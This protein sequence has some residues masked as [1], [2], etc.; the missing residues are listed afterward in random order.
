MIATIAFITSRHQPRFDWFLESLFRQISP[1]DIIQVIIVDFYAQSCDEW[2]KYDADKRDEKLCGL[3]T[4]LQLPSN[5]TVERHP[6]MPS[7]WQ[8][9]DRLTKENWWA[10]AAARNTALCYAKHSWFLHLDDRCVLQPGFLDAARENMLESKFTFGTYQKRTGITVEN[11]LIKNGGI[12]TANDSRA[13]YV[14]QHRSN[15]APTPCPGEWYF[16]C[17]G[18]GPLEWYL[19]VNGWDT[20]CDGQSME[21]TI[22]GLMIANNGYPTFFDNRMAIVEDRTPEDS[23]PV[24]IRRDK[25]VSPNDRSHA[26]LDMLKGLK[27]AKHNVDLREIRNSILNG[28]SFPPAMEPILDWYDG[29]LLSD[30]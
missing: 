6:P 16:G 7:V 21:D 4:Y 1:S 20:T 8:G 19:S 3:L 14:R 22:L 13:D 28:K 26:L 17:C 12:I 24:M 10:M 11:G 29:Q 9:S 18:M 2:T 30:M 5:I 25:G 27:R 15:A 23:G